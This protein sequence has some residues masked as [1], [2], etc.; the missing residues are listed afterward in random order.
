[1]DWKDESLWKCAECGRVF[2]KSNQWHS[3]QAKRVTD[4]FQGKVPQL[5]E[6]FDVLIQ[7]LEESGP[8]RINTVK[9]SINLINRHHFG[10]TKVQR[11]ALRVGFVTNEEIMSERIIRRQRLGP[12]RVGYS[13]N[14]FAWEDVDEELIERLRNA[15]ILQS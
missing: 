5:K 3:C 9:T 1:M 7:R 8:I 11:K 4:H 12:N 6:I 2:A 15:Y 13:V 10:G 14:L